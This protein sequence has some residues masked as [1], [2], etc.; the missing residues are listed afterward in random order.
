M[1]TLHGHVTHEQSV[2]FCHSQNLDGDWCASMYQCV[3]PPDAD[4]AEASP[5]R[6]G[7][8]IGQPLAPGGSGTSRPSCPV[9]WPFPVQ[10]A[11][12]GGGQLRK[13]GAQSRSW[14]LLPVA[15]DH[16]PEGGGRAYKDRGV[17]YSLLYLSLPHAVQTA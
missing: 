8:P 11:V 12:N 17:F 16:S 9:R 1:H 13:N 6:G 5:T 7:Q 15:G 14:G 3:C 4:F 10:A 2:H